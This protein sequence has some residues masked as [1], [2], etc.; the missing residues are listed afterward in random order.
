MTTLLDD[1]SITET[2]AERLRTTM[3]AVRVSFT[4]LGVRKTLTPEQKNQAADTFGAEGG[5]LSAGKK[6][7]DTAHPAF[8]AVTAIRGRIIGLWKSIS[9]PYPENGVRLIRQDRIDEFAG[10]MQELREE[11]AEAVR[12]LDRHYSELKAAARQRLGRLFNSAD[13][14]DSLTGLFGVE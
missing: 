14:P 3:A 5:F 6:L 7:L 2:P 1:H 12:Q 8:K 11:L 13:Y 9:L 4:W 10:K